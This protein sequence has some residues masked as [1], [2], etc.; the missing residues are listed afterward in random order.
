MISGYAQVQETL[1]VHDLSA[2]NR[3]IRVPSK[4]LEIEDVQDVSANEELI[5]HRNTKTTATEWRDDD[6]NIEGVRELNRVYERIP[7]SREYEGVLDLPPL[8]LEWS[9]G[10][11]LPVAW[12][13]G[14]A[15]S[16]GDTIVLAVGMWMPDRLNVVLTRMTDRPMHTPNCR[17]VRLRPNTPKARTTIPACMSWAAARPGGR[18]GG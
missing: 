17:L 3:E 18:Y 7:F 1:E 11:N 8:K 12:K 10:A 2:D 5:M 9:T 6:V 15:G 4:G 14:V 16:F 13:G